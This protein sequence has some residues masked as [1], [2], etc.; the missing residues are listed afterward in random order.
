MSRI[1]V[2]AMTI[3]KARV[4]FSDC[5]RS[6]ESGEIVVVTRYGKPV[7]A[8]ISAKYLAELEGARRQGLASQG[9][10]GLVDRFSDGGEF[11]AEVEQIVLERC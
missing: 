2:K 1:M 3:A 5:V 7:A 8:M 9:L 11:A 10:A 6:A 4:R